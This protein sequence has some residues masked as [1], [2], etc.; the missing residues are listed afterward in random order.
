MR[1]ESKGLG[2][3]GTPVVPLFPFYFG[4]TVLKLNAREKGTLIIKG[5]LEN[6]DLASRI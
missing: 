2:F 3:L 6:L 5:L 4:V 1:A